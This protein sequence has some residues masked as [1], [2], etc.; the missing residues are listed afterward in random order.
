MNYKTK[1]ILILTIL[2][3]G[4]SS[5]LYY[6]FLYN[7]DLSSNIYKD[8]VK[9]RVEKN[10]NLLLQ[11]NR[12]FANHIF[13]QHINTDKII[14]LFKTNQREKLY[15]LLKDDYQN[16]KSE[17]NVRQ[18]HFHSKEMSSFLRMHKPNKYGDSL[19]GIRQSVEYANKNKK[20]F[21]TFE[22]GR[23]FNG[24]R[25]IY[26][27]FDH[28]TDEFIGTVE[29]SFSA[30]TIINGFVNN[31][32]SAAN[33]LINGDVVDKK[34]FN[35]EKSNYVASPIDGFY[36]D[37]LIL[38]KLKKID[39]NIKSNKKSPK[40]LKQLSSKILE[41]DTF[42][43]NFKNA[44]ELVVVIPIK[45]K[46][47]NKVIA[48][49]NIMEK[50]QFIK[51]EYEDFIFKF[52]SSIFIL[53]L[54]VLFIY[55]TIIS[56]RKAIKEQYEINQKLQ[57]KVQ[58]A[59]LENTKQLQA[60][61]Q[62]S[63]LASM[64]EMIGAIA[65]QWRQPLN[66]I[67]TSIQNLKY[68]YED[69]YLNDQK[70]VYDFIDKNKKTVMFMSKTIDDFRNFYRIDKEK[71]DFNIKEVTQSVIDMQIIQLNNNKIEIS[72]EGEDFIFY[73][74][75]S[76]Y[77]QVI[78]NL[79]NNAKDILVEKNIEEPKIEII[80]ENRSTISVKDNGG[81]ISDEVLDRI[82]EP[83]FTTKEQGKG[84]GM[85]LYM[86]KMII[87]DNMDCKLDVKNRDDGAC[88]YIEFNKD[89]LKS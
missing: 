60:L 32:D 74:L 76:E 88:F 82:F 42:I 4:I 3:I 51:D 25:H 50:D 56:R 18:V 7:M 86:S 10:Y 47:T 9:D 37:K 29:I 71:S 39:K 77:Q 53:L 44:G 48:S 75:E 8:Q 21:E 43:V 22:E 27:I 62:Q 41:G 19:I 31:F 35:T 2:Y 81:G 24:F 54:I 49:I 85:G 78:L 28:Q 63:K 34:V 72:L 26:P 6:I 36:F 20:Y 23:I 45:N 17:F 33:F 61:Q 38:N 30:Y 14:K 68:D 55:N 73:G 87:E 52:A 70:F 69:G 12:T 15:E 67:S 16:W 80:L 83:Y 11:E 1:L 46:L 40:I 57:Q 79:L 65:H 5:S 89:Y 59:L 58:E 66:V 84:T 13:Y 64:G